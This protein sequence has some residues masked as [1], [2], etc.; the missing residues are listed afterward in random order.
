MSKHQVLIALGG[1]LGDRE[2]MLASARQAMQGY[3]EIDAESGVYETEPWGFEDQPMFLNQVI[4]G[5]TDLAPAALLAAL[6]ATETELGRRASFRYG[7]RQI[8]LDLLA[9]DDR[10]VEQEDL[11]VPHPRMPQR[12]FVLVP[13]AEV[14]PDWTHPITGRTAE[15]MLTELDR[16]SVHP[17]PG[18]QEKE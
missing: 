5:R 12:A 6:K 9:F 11:V 10:V 8:D 3:L 13:L 7:P 18:D 15:Q 14:A 2:S 1:N 4:R 17:W 16:S